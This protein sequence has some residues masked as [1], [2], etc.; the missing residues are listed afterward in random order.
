M[1]E[2]LASLFLNAL[3]RSYDAGDTVFL[4]GDPVSHVY[5]VVQGST[6]LL[7][8]LPNGDMAQLQRANTGDV[9]A[10]A[11]VYATSYHCDCKATEPTVLAVLPKRSFKQMLREDV[12]ISE[13]WAAYL[14]R[15]VQIMRMRAE[16][17]SLK[18]VAERL[19]TWLA[20]YG[21]MPPKGRWQ[22]LAQEL[23]VS[24]E[25]LYRELALRR[26]NIR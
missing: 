12:G 17:R 8:V 19:D 7:R 4:T 3:R 11:S 18:T 5:C 24:K 25:A 22:D 21:E 26:T 23:S 6:A 15:S 13:V 1:S 10:E 16:I 14:A 2:L 20:E 9:V